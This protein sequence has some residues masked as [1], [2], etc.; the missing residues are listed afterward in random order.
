M[1]GESSP[2]RECR[3]RAARR[4]G[5][6][7]CGRH[8]CDEDRHRRIWRSGL[9]S[10]AVLAIALAALVPTVGDLGLT[11]DEPAYR[12]SQVMSAQWWEQLGKCPFLA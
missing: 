2:A 12:Y 7:R 8:P 1:T 6:G 11:W 3:G 10:L 4:P 5:P 9:G